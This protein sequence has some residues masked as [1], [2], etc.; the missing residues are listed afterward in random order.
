MRHVQ[1]ARRHDL[2]FGRGELAARGRAN[3]PVQGDLGQAGGR[4]V[5]EAHRIRKSLEQL[6]H[7]GA[8]RHPAHGS[9]DA[10][11][12]LA[13]DDGFEPG[14]VTDRLDDFVDRRV[15]RPQRQLAVVELDFDDRRRSRGNRGRRAKRDHQTDCG[16]PP[17]RAQHRRQAGRNTD[18]II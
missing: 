7:R 14:N 18:R 1:R 2:E 11:I 6:P 17:D 8:P 13:D 9:I 16:Q 15:R 10:P 4:A 3:P 12:E 5:G